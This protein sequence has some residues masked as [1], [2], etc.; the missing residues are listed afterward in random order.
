MNPVL[1]GSEADCGKRGFSDV[2][3]AVKTVP[4]LVLRYP[5]CE[6]AAESTYL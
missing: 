4:L 6:S 1:V 3:V 5:S 2:V